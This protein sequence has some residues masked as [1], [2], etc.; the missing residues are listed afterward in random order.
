LSIAEGS[1]VA[2]IMG[3]TSYIV[4]VLKD[5]RF[6]TH[7]GY[8]ELSTLIGKPYGS[9]SKTST[10]QEFLVIR[11]STRDY[12][13][14]LSRATQVIYPKDAAA[15]LMWGD[16]KPGQRVLESGTGSGALTAC[17]AEIVGI[18]GV[19]YGFDLKQSS[20]EKTEENLKRRRLLARVQ[21]RQADVSKGVDLSDLDAVVL[22]LP[23]PW[24]A[25]KAL[26]TSLKSDGFFVSFSP[27]MNQVE[28]TVVALKETGFVGVEAFELIQRFLDAKPNATRP[29]TVGVYHTGYIVAAR[30]TE[31]SRSFEPPKPSKRPEEDSPST[32][33]FFE[34]F[35]QS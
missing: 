19:V 15:I 26:K 8:I 23:S 12:T 14:K 33:E 25:V 2:I 18:D 29:N 17:L 27:T 9:V 35:D 22:D 28:K 4:T 6:H 13:T 34:S 31:L 10:N 24:I 7:R 1:D 16:I 3:K 30:N 20:L 5:K 11:P 21:L 32:Y